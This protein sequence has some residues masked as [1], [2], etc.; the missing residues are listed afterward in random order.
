VIQEVFRRY[1]QD[2]ATL[3]SVSKYLLQRGIKS[4]RGQRCWRS[5]TLRGV[6]SNPA[7]TGH[8]YVDRPQ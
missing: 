1:A 6:L 8:V 2:H 7:Y 3:V 4:P 5:A